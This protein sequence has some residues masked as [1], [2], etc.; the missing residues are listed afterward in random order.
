MTN[1]TVAIHTLYICTCTF[2]SGSTMRQIASQGLTCNAGNAHKPLWRTFCMRRFQ[3]YETVHSWTFLHSE[4]MIFQWRSILAGTSFCFFF[5]ID[6]VKRTL[7]PMYTSYWFVSVWIKTLSVGWV[8]AAT[9]DFCL[10]VHLCCRAHFA[11]HPY[12]EAWTSQ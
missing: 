7:N 4:A 5:V 12:P 8:P 1:C 9:W 10:F 3:D 6:R 2:S 11:S